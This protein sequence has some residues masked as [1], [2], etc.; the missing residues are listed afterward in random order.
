MAGGS[1]DPAGYPIRG[2]FEKGD[3]LSIAIGYLQN[4]TTP[5]TPAPY[6]SSALNRK[7]AGML[8]RPKS[9]KR[10]WNNST[11][12]VW[13]G[14]S[15]HLMAVRHGSDWR[16]YRMEVAERQDVS[17]GTIDYWLER[18]RR[19]RGFDKDL[20]RR[21]LIRAQFRQSNFPAESE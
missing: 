14:A 19:E 3:N 13:I 17:V 10:T 9:L 2:L 20:A 12:H 7:H 21:I 1:I 16:R 15:L 8:Y 18:Y 5:R 6:D 4:M 11:Y